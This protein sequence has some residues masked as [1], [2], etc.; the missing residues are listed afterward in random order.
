MSNSIIFPK[1]I[2]FYDWASQIRNTITT[3]SF[4]IPLHQSLW[5]DWAFQVIILNPAEM[6][7]VPHPNKLAFPKETDWTKWASFFVFALI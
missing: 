2:S 1:G 6:T 3:I 5:H 7:R 4:P